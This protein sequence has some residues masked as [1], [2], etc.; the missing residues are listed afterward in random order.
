MGASAFAS[1]VV[2][3]VFG[4]T[5]APRLGLAQAGP[6]SVVALPTPVLEG[7]VALERALSQRRST[8]QLPPDTLTISQVGQLLWAAQGMNRPGRGRT[9]PSA[10]ATYPLDAYLV[11]GAVAELP[12]GIYRYRPA[13]HD[14][15]RVD[16]GDRRA[17]LAEAALR[18]TWIASVP[19][20]L[21]LV[22]D[23]SRTTSRYG[24]RGFRFTHI[25]AGAAAQN[26]YLQ[27]VTLGLGTTFVGAF[28]DARAGVVL[29]LGTDRTALGLLPVGKLPPQAR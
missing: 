14:L 1:L 23:Y 29:S 10:G 24:D 7:T 19:A 26:V 6:D 2:A 15:V 27:C 25:E 28:D 5:L 16:T 18:Q 3:L 4:A 9:A 12:A 22:A 21:V 20:V 11:A 13:R 17:A 8:R